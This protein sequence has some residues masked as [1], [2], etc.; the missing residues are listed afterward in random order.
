MKVQPITDMKSIRAIKRLLADNKRDLLLFTM[1]INTGLRVQDLLA[2]RIE[3]VE[4]AA[5]GDRI[6][7]REKKTGKDNVIIINEE[8]YKA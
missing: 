2:L 4:N 3:Q 7:I 6:P 8:I 5:V 1:G